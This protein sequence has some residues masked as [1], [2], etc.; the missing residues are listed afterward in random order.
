MNIFTKVI[1]LITKDNIKD[2]INIKDLIN[3]PSRKDITDINKIRIIDKYKS[4]YKKILSTSRTIT[5][6]DLDSD[7]IHYNLKMNIDLLLNTL[8]NHEN[9]FNEFD[10]KLNYLKLGIYYNETL[11]IEDEVIL[12]IN[13]LKE[14]LREKVFITK[15]K[16]D[17]LKNE[18]TNLEIVFNIICSNKIAIQ[19]EKESFFKKYENILKENINKE[20]NIKEK[21][22]KINSFASII[23]KSFNIN[24]YKSIVD[25][26]FLE[27]ELEIYVY[28][29]KKDVKPL[30]EEVEEYGI[31]CF[32]LNNNYITRQRIIESGKR[33]ENHLKL[34]YYYGHNLIKPSDMKKFYEIKFYNF[35]RCLCSTDNAQLEL[36]KLD[37]IELDCYKVLIMKLIENIVTDKENRLEKIFKDKKYSVINLLIKILK[38]GKNEFNPE[39]ILNN[40]L[41][42]IILK[43]FGNNPNILKIDYFFKEYMINIYEEFNLFNGEVISI[44][45]I[46]NTNKIP[47]NYSNNLS[48]KSFF[49]LDEI[50]KKINKY[51]MFDYNYY[52]LETID[53]TLNSDF[54][55]I[56]YLKKLYLIVKSISEKDLNNENS[57]FVILN[58]IRYLNNGYNK[59]S[60]SINFLNE[61]FK[62]MKDGST[63]YMPPS[64]EEIRGNIFNDKKIN[65]LVLNEGLVQW[66]ENPAF[67][68]SDMHIKSLKTLTIPSTLEKLELNIKEVETLFFN[69]YKHNIILND[70]EKLY[71]LLYKTINIYGCNEKN[72]IVLNFITSIKE[73]IL[74]DE[75]GTAVSLNIKFKRKNKIYKENFH[76]ERKSLQEK[77]TYEICQFIYDK[78]RINKN[79]TLR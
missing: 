22:K 53:N 49:E 17:A 72:N 26:A 30:I 59:K 67:I 69:N 6:K 76:H 44:S 31:K 48:L 56:K 29:H 42:L 47:N 39:L 58:G 55:I 35:L 66:L 51:H 32:V 18:I 50:F 54:N 36:N 60:L 34:F 33:L 64:L 24:N 5:S 45:D 63:V 73:I 11:K 23:D 79:K 37:K 57:D 40:S 10:L 68:V 14:L 46:L 77:F 38:N 15:N 25:I 43:I 1:F 20:N 8:Y 41:L 2:I 27:R 70:R 74:V 78:I 9:L 4:D 16:K 28:K 12:R 3:I 13:A 71:K 21:L 61:L 52:K 7:S 65:K 75:D 19:K 62:T